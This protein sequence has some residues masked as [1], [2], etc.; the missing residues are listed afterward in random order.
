MEEACNNV[1]SSPDPKISAPVDSSL[2]LRHASSPLSTPPR[3]PECEEVEVALEDL[4]N[5][6]SPPPKSVRYIKVR[7]HYVGRGK[8]LPYS[9]D[10]LDLDDET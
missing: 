2:A 10:D 8:P 1:P 6:K 9:A 4:L 5:Y 3:K 7:Y